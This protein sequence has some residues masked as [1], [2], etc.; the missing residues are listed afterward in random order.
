MA[1]NTGGTRGDVRQSA[2]WGSGNRGGEFR[3][4]AL[5]GKGGKGIIVSLALLVVPMLGGGVFTA[6]SAPAPTYVEPGLLERAQQNPHEMFKV[7]VQSRYGADEAADSFKEAE[8]ADDQALKAEEEQAER[9][10]KKAN[11]AESK[12]KKKADRTRLRAERERWKAQRDLLKRLPK[13]LRGDLEEKFDFIAG[14]ELEIAGRRLVRLARLPGLSITEDVPV[15]LSSTVDGYIWPAAAGVLPLLGSTSKPAPNAPA[16][17]IVDSGIEHNRSDFGNGSR[18]IA[19]T[20]LT[21]LE[22]NSAGDGRGHG[23]FVA[24]IA[25][26]SAPGRPGASPTSPIV[27]VDV[28]D[29]SGMA[30][31][32]D[33]IAGAEWILANKDKYNIRVANFS[34]HSARPSNFT[35]DPLDH[36]VEKLWFAGVVVVAAA[37]NY[38]SPDGPSGVKFAPGNDPFI[39][40]VGAVDLDGSLRVSKHDVPTWSAYGRTYDGFMKPDLAAPGRYMIGAV[41]SN[42][43]LVAEKPGNRVGQ[44]YIRLSGTSFSAPVVAGAAAQILARHP[45]WTPDQV[46]GALMTTARRLTDDEVPPGSAGVGEINAWKASEVKNPPNPNKGLNRYLV[47]DAATGAVSFDAVSWADAARASVSWDSVSWADVSWTDV[48]WADVSWADVMAVADVSW[49]DAAGMET[50]PQGGDYVVTDTVEG[51]F[52]SDPEL[53]PDAKPV[54]EA[55][56]AVADAVEDTV[57]EVE[58]TV[59]EVED[60]VEEVEETVEDAVDDVTDVV[61]QAPGDLGLPKPEPPSAP[62]P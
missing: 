62:L 53:N 19:R 59:E 30:R 5:W 48:S 10:E 22:K 9:A 18:V 61:T 3:T 8:R 43:T 12:A 17:A 40:T 55:A 29:D 1:R 37:G 41:P 42:S 21:K 54:E 38:G 51:E 15:K 49:E 31:T 6:Q 44:G 46:K 39:I 50:E 56:E 45:N 47:S 60:T 58:D 2:L 7:I 32:S 34:L 28:M 52:A 27:D 33:V 11:D 16:I 35:K 36:A 25:A 14:V 23:T 24:S 26:G 13:Q 4:N 57:E 20:V